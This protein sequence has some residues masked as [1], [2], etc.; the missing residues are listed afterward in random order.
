MTRDE[1]PLFPLNTVLFPDGPL[2]L[3]IFETRY[4]DMVS[5]CMRENLAFG[6][7]L[8]V[9]TGEHGVARLA[10]TGTSARIVD[11]NQGSEGLLYI[12]AR[13]ER[14][15]R[16]ASVRQQE[17]GL[18]MAGVEW[19]PD[20]DGDAPAALLQSTAEALQVLFATSGLLYQNIEKR[21]NDAS[22][23]GF[24]LAEILPLAAETRQRCLEMNDAG[25]RLQLLQPVLAQ[26]V[27]GQHRRRN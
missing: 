3:R 19:L 24:R 1:I 17:D 9:T 10:E 26:V 22:W 21:Y 11:F 20:A 14:R 8:M 5:K 27:S 12:T 23:V 16:L 13:G 15:F 2:P 7:V 4:V 6:V 18:N 25:L